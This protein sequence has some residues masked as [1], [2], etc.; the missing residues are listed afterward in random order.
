[1]IRTVAAMVVLVGLV[2]SAASEG[3]DQTSELIMGMV[4]NI[5][6]IR[7]NGASEGLARKTIMGILENSITTDGTNLSEQNKLKIRL[8]V[9]KVITTIYE[10]NLQQII[11]AK[12]T[13]DDR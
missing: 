5:V 9:D 10:A 1:M 3:A 6:S 12:N 11:T 7:I 8:A 2:V 13:C 4:C